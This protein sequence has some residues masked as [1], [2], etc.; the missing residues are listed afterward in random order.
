MIGSNM[1]DREKALYRRTVR[2]FEPA[3]DLAQEFWADCKLD[4]LVELKGSRPR[5]PIFHRLWWAMLGDMAKNANPPMTSKQLDFMAK[6]GTGTGEWRHVVALK[7]P[8][9]G[10]MVPVFMPGSISFAAMDEVEFR[11]FVREAAAFLCESFFPGVV[12]DH[13]IREFETL[14]IGGE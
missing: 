8:Q 9:K 11:R 14:A 10:K 6:V 5:N 13:F 2:G 4:E 3:N 12:P 7:G 1:A